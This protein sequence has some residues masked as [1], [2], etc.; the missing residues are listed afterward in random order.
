MSEFINVPEGRDLDTDLEALVDEYV[1]S[2]ERDDN[3][4]GAWTNDCKRPFGNSGNWQIARDILN[5]IGVDLTDYTDDEGE[6][7]DESKELEQYAHDLYGEIGPFL[8]QKWFERKPK[9][10]NAEHPELPADAG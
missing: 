6:D 2:I 4:Y 8:Y 9:K 3:C 5:I 7:T 10:A 1:K